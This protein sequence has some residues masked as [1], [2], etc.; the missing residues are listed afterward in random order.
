MNLLKF[1]RSACVYVCVHNMYVLEIFNYICVLANS[2]AI[3]LSMCVYLKKHARQ[4]A[5]HGTKMYTKIPEMIVTLETLSLGACGNTYMK[6]H[7]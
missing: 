6:P 4:L 5:M 7:K 2:Y 3:S 1:F